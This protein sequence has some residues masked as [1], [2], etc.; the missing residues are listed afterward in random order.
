MVGG[1]A[2]AGCGAAG[3]VAVIVMGMILSAVPTSSITNV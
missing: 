1:D 3:G 2:A